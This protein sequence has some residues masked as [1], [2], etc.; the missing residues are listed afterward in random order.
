MSNLTS[1]SSSAG[2]ALALPGGSKTLRICAMMVSPSMPGTRGCG[3]VMI[4][5]KCKYIET[6]RR[7]SICITI[8]GDK[9]SHYRSFHI[10]VECDDLLIY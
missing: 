4:I 5:W 8:T 7:H 3:S 9:L 6:G 1:V 2:P 10:M